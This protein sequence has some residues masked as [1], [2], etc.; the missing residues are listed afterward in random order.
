MKLWV[1]RPRVDVEL[2]YPNHGTAPKHYIVLHQTISGDAPG[3]SDIVGVG[4]YLKHVGYAI[5]MIVDAEGNSA[6]VSPAHETDIYYHCQDFNSNS[7]GIEQVSFKK[8]IAGYWWTRLKQLN[9][10][11]RWIAYLS[12]AHNIPIQ[13]DQHL[14][15][16]AGVVGHY[17]VT[18]AKKIYGG[19]TDCQYPDYPM[20]TVIRLATAY[21]KLGWA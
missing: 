14:T 5:H 6:A 4:N 10:V 11:A 15:L 2:S 16:G 13:W 8:G 21:R 18:V 1:R 7:I 3:I 19:H 9:K 20:K 17:D 12:K